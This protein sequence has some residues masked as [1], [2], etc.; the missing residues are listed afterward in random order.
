MV[1]FSHFT[2]QYATP[3]FSFK[4]FLIVDNPAKN[5]YDGHG[6]N[7]QP[8]LTE[9][10]IMSNKKTIMI[11][12]TIHNYMFCFHKVWIFFFNKKEQV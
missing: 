12:A 7:P 8:F 4:N 2:V 1:S 6:E 3:F 5:G 11:S 9:E 10:T